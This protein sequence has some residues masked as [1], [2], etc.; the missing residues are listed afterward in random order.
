MIFDICPS[1]IIILTK[2]K[3]EVWCYILKKKDLLQII[4]GEDQ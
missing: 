3:W 2:T 4:E 1:Y